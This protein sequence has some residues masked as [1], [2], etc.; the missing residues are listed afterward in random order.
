M[1]LASQS[2]HAHHFIFLKLVVAL[3]SE[4]VKKNG[5]EP[6]LTLFCVIQ[7]TWPWEK[8]GKKMDQS[9]LDQ[10][11]AL[12]SCCILLMH[13]CMCV[14]YRAPTMSMISKIRP[15]CVCVC[16]VWIVSIQFISLG[17]DAAESMQPSLTSFRFHLCWNLTYLSLQPP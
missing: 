3:D 13:V 8:G 10:H 5:G 4:M 1:P 6:A 11:L 9:N 7:V 16:L 17:V 12:K 2:V 15:V 14:Y